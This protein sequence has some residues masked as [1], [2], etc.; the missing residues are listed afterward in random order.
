MSRSNAYN[1][2]RR[3]EL[4][5]RQEDVV[6]LIAKGLTNAEIAERLGVTLDGAKWHVREILGK[7][8]VESREEAAAEWERQRSAGSRVRMW[9]G[10]LW[11]STAARWV[12]GLAVAGAGIAAGTGIAV[13]L[14]H[15]EQEPA[16][17][18]V[19][20]P[21]PASPA[22]KEGLTLRIESVEADDTQTTVTFTLE[23]R[24]ELGRLASPPFVPG[25][26]KLTDEHG[27]EYRPRSSAGDGAQRRQRFVFDP[28]LAAARTLILSID[29]AGFVAPEGETLPGQRPPDPTATVS[30]PWVVEYHE[31]WQRQSMAVAVDPA[32]R[33]FGPGMVVV[34]AVLQTPTETVV[35][36][37]LVDW[38]GGS[39]V[40][41]RPGVTLEGG[42]IQAEMTS[43]RWGE[44]PGET[45]MEFRFAKLAGSVTLTVEGLPNPRFWEGGAEQVYVL[46]GGQQERTPEQEAQVREQRAALAAMAD[47][48]A[49]AFAGQQP[50]TWTFTLP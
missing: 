7:F 33:V 43:G 41:F 34:D 1:P 2:A 31:F 47:A 6:R 30:G 40:S 50:A 12:G 36:A 42:G 21:S 29:S 4:T 15:D 48:I 35:R 23:G 20:L 16:K 22:T 10:S 39:S 17:A 14:R 8:G 38:P 27:N 26:V 13:T 5:K 45:L 18:V 11:T 3:I 24:P 37:R 46:D 28:A 9:S 32:P 19:A 49:E 25:R 44:G